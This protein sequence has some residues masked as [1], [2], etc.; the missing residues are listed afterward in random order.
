MNA[1]QWLLIGPSGLAARRLVAVVLDK[2][3]DVKLEMMRPS[4][5]PATRNS[6]RL[7]SPRISHAHVTTVY[8]NVIQHV[9]K[10]SLM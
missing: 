3:L 6:V 1:N 5:V 2:E 7:T 10:V 4:Q 8:S 9:V